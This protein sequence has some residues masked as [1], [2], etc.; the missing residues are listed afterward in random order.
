MKEWIILL[1]LAVAALSLV[2]AGVVCYCCR[3]MERRKNLGILRAV[4]EQDRLAKEL[5][6]ARIEKE[7]IERVLRSKLPESGERHAAPPKTP[8]TS[9]PNQDASVELRPDSK[10]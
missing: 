6:R 8:P 10:I 3:R 5:E 2:A 1:A 7:T 9:A 4:H